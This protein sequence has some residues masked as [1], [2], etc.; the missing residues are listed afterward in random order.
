MNYS[1]S[2]S[3]Y[4]NAGE[5]IAECLLKDYVIFFSNGKSVATKLICYTRTNSLISDLPEVYPR[6]A[7]FSAEDLEMYK[8][9][10]RTL[11]FD[12]VV[13]AI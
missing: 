11:I 6:P 5:L 1:Q 4:L 10:I 8:K 3:T 2:I 9:S 7:Y 13:Y 12:Q